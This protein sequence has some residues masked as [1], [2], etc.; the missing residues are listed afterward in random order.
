MKQYYTGS[1]LLDT[2]VSQTTLHSSEESEQT[3]SEIIN[4]RRNKVVFVHT[5]KAYRSSNGT[6]PQH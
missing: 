4:I 1:P 3:V 2:L 5:M 6:A